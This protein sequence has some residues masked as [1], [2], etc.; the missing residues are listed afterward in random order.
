MLN[1][2]L[3]LQWDWPEKHRI[4]INICMVFWTRGPWR[5]SP[6]CLF[7]P[8]CTRCRNYFFPVPTSQ[9]TLIFQAKTSYRPR[10]PWC[11]QNK[12]NICH[13][14]KWRCSPANETPQTFEN[15]LATLPAR[16]KLYVTSFFRRISL[17]PPLYFAPSFFSQYCIFLFP[18]LTLTLFYSHVL[19]VEL[20]RVNMLNR[21]EW[22][23]LCFQSNPEPAV[24]A[25]GWRLDV[26]YE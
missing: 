19:Y 20:H 9:A 13:R 5:Y 21:K 12:F 16:K 7:K 1:H 23:I 6:L 8:L 2:S 10:G 26:L 15:C 24:F 17:C 18:P 14:I 22:V 4:Q 3:M 11:A 25:A